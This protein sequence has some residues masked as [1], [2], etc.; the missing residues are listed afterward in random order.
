VPIEYVIAVIMIATATLTLLER[1]RSMAARRST[2]ALRALVAAPVS[3]R[4]EP[5]SPELLPVDRVT[6]RMV[7]D[8]CG[9]LQDSL[10]AVSREREVILSAVT[11][12]VIVMD[13]RGKVLCVNRVQSEWLRLPDGDILGRSVIEVLRDHEVYEIAR[14]C[15]TTGAEERALIEVGPG[16]RFMQVSATPLDARSGCVIVLQDRTEVQRLEKVRR[17]FVSNISHELRTP[18]ATLKLLSETLSLDSG[19]DP[20]LLRDYLGRIEVEVDRLAQI[21]DELGELSLIETG[22][23]T[24]QRSVVD[25]VAVARRA[26]ERLES[27]SARAGLTVTVGAPDVPA[28]VCGDERRLEQVL[29]NLI[30]NAIKF[31]APGGTIH[32]SAKNG[33]SAVVVAVEDSGIGIPSEE[34]GRIFERLYKVD[35]SRSSK[36]TGLGLAIARHVIELHGGTI[37]AESEEGKGSSFFFALPTAP[38]G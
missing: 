17:E 18:L 25:I 34:L 12:G 27:Q 11:D 1:K 23:V 28:V 5:P 37:W 21:V 7:L 29:V 26:A 15:L 35:R 16:K 30:H 10:V 19:D 8:A 31:T 6:A 3:R 9:A 36:G 33:E 24:L 22:Q 38:R 14:R 2:E 32:V 13:D 4:Q 20:T